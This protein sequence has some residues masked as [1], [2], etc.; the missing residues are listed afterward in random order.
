MKPDIRSDIVARFE[1]HQHEL[2]QV[3]RSSEEPA[4]ATYGNLLTSQQDD[5]L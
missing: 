3:I 5:C 1:A 4:C 2:K